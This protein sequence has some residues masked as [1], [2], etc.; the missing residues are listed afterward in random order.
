MALEFLGNGS[1][2]ADEHTSAYFIAK[3]DFVL[4][5]CPVSAFQK[6]K[7]MNLK[8]YKNIYVLITHTHGDHIGGLGLLVQYVYFVLNKYVTIVTPSLELHDDIVTLMRIEGNDPKWYRADGLCAV[9]WEEWYYGAI[10]TNHSPNLEEKCFGYH[11]VIDGENVIYTGDTCELA[12]FEPYIR[13]SKGEKRLYV[14]TSVHYGAIHLKLEEMLPKLIEFTENGVQ[15]YLMHLDDIKA[16][17]EIIKDY[18]NI[19]IVE[20]KPL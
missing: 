8:D 15:V 19:Q 3:E 10:K 13:Y 9:L 16:A 11:L 12:P 6:L 7:R 17:K 2:F 20:V 14:D 5:D 4:I 18:S 1:G